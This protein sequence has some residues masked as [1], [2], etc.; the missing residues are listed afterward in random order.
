VWGKLMEE[1]QEK[2]EIWQKSSVLTKKIFHQFC[3]I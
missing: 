2:Y 1:L 3:S